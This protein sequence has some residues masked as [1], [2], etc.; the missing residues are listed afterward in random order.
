MTRRMMYLHA[1]SEEEEAV[2]TIQKQVSELFDTNAEGPVKYVSLYDQYT[3]LLDGTT[4]TEVMNFIQECGELKEGNKQLKKLHQLGYEVMQLTDYVPLALIILNCNDVNNQLQ[5]QVQ[6]L[7]T[8]IQ[9][10]FIQKNKDHDKE[11]CYAFDDM[12][13]KLSQVTDVT[14][15]IVELSNYL[16]VC[17]S[18]TMTQL[19]QEIQN[20]TDR[21]LFLLQYGKV[22]ED[23]VLLINRMYAWPHKIS[24]DFH[25]AEARLAHK[26]DLKESA[27]KQRVAEFEKTLSGFNKEL[28]GLRMRDS[29]SMKEIRVD[30][31]KR[32][33]EMLDRLTTQLQEAKNELQAINEEQSLLS[34]EATKFPLLAA[35]ASQ[36][37]PY[38]KLWHTAYDFHQ[39]YEKWYNGPFSGLDAEAINDDVENMWRTMY[40]LTKTFMDQVGSRRVA[41]YV[42]ERIEKFRHHVPVLQCICNPGLRE[43]HWTQLG[44]HLGKELN[45]TSETS[46]ADM[47][48]VGLP[49]IQ[50][51]LEE[52]SHAASKEFSLEKALEKMKG[53]W[54]NVVF[55]FKAWR[56]TGVSILAAVD[57]IQVLLDEHTQKV[58]TMRGSP[59]VK[60]FENEIRSWEEKLLSMQDIL[61]AW[62]KCQ[63]TW[64]YLE[65]IFSSE[66]IM[67]QMP[68]EG[69]KFT[70]V[71]QAWREMMATAVED[72]HALV[73]TAQPNMLPRLHECNDLLEEIQ[74][75][76]NDYLE[77][78]RLFFP[79]FFF[80]S[81]D[82]LL[83]ILSETKD[84][85]R[86]QPHLKKCFEGISRL[87]FS[88]QQ[89]IE[90]MLSSEGELVQFSN[91]VVPAKAR[92][93]VER[94]LVEVEEMMIQSLQDVAVRAVENHPSIDHDTW[95]VQ[96]PSQIV[97]TVAQI[98]WTSDV[99]VAIEEK[100]IKL[101]L[102]V[103]NARIEEVVTMVRGKLEPGT[104]ST[105]GALIV[106]Y[107]H[108]RDVVQE[109]NNKQVCSIQ[110]FTWVSQLRY[111]WVQ[112]LVKVDMVMTRLP[113]GYEYL[114]NTSRLVI[115]PLTDRC[116]RTLMG[117]LKLNLG[118][119]PE[120]PAGTGKT[121][122]CKDLAKAAAKQCII[123]NCS[124]GLDYKAM[125]KF[126]KGLA[127]SGAWACFDEFNR[128]ELEVLSVVAQ[129]IQNIQAAISRGAQ[130]FIFEGVDLALNPNCSIFITMNPGYM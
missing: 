6:E 32:N 63:V 105:L 125:G 101:L 84:P 34:W 117:S 93:L 76:L 127:Q 20:A 9:D 57:D 60:P 46:L 1:V 83:E 37:E 25:M 33:V 42:K 123:F 67:K 118:G 16:H 47:I 114:G 14:A 109:L 66:D 104:R 35:M 90:G 50:R 98:V 110:D 68:V 15:E 108:G 91:R 113:Y 79:R 3:N 5:V 119:A 23:Q 61:D 54:S 121:E 73:A 43:R 82:E 81:N 62:I 40:K 77:K 106:T 56:E 87:H 86:V 17:S 85:Q 44:E 36:K 74:K 11:I 26:R 64:L 126:F 102:D 97:L 48:E 2:K 129:Q 29:F 7:T 130:R 70:R 18:Q 55:E 65:P 41:E 112:E 10:Y 78:K 38:D 13:T 128:I 95:I 4:H 31:M 22:P 88:S 45:L 53:E 39:K 49:S 12:S 107:V 80:L 69:R 122:T 28:E 94:W 27:L 51:K 100:S 19:L 103:C 124:D 52:I 120:G 92:G 111:Y 58:Q 59:Y 21:L 75:G 96:W 116:F 30:T 24:E 99:T 115:T 8:A 89:E 71:D 72:P